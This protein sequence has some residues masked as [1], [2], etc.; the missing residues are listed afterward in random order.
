[1]P[2]MAYH[3]LRENENTLKMTTGYKY[4]SITAYL[5]MCEEK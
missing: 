1:M 2:L 4:S 5:K 3:A